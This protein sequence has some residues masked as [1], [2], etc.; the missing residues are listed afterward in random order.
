MYLRLRYTDPDVTANIHVSWLDP[1]KVRRVTVVGSRKM[2]VYN[3]LAPEERIRI[4]DK[5]LVAPEDGERPQDIPMSYRYGEIRA[6]FLSFE[7]PLAVQDRE[8]ASCVL[9]GSRPRADGDN[10]LAVVAA[11][12]SADISLQTGNPVHLGELAEFGRAGLELVDV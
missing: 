5:G 8:F 6:P 2:V 4:F 11:L 9:T 10:G 12:E 1:C 3:D 7:E